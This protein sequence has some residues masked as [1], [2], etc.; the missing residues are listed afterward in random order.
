MSISPQLTNRTTIR[1]ESLTSRMTTSSE[2][3]R[4]QTYSG[5]VATLLRIWRETNLM[6]NKASRWSSSGLVMRKSQVPTR[7][8]TLLEFIQLRRTCAIWG[9]YRKRALTWRL[10]AKLQARSLLHSI[11]TMSF[12]RI[13]S[14]CKTKTKRMKISAQAVKKEGIEFLHS[15]RAKRR[16][17]LVSN[18]NKMR[19]RSPRGATHQSLRSHPSSSLVPSS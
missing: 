1:V 15:E 5:M 18:S 8:I 6:Q 9:R 12:H 16:S 3:T 11:L 7:I 4:T 17:D 2:W 13:N 10:K 14:R 19:N